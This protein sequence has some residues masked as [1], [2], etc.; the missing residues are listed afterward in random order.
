MF[1]IGGADYHVFKCIMHKALKRNW[2]RPIARMF[3]NLASSS[4]FQALCTL[5]EKGVPFRKRIV[6][7]HFGEHHEDWFLRLNPQ[8]KVPV[9][10]DGDKVVVESEEIINYI[11]RRCPG[12]EVEFGDLP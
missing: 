6:Y 2:P 9:L 1:S 4:F 11:D 12:G 7:F 10:Q 5:H 3:E 8:G